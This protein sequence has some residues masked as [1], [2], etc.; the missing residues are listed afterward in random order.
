M[1]GMMCA[2]IGSSIYLTFATRIGLPCSTT[3][4]IMGGVIGTGVALVG[5]DGIK[6]WGGNIHS[7]VVQVFLAWVIAPV[8][9]AAFASIIFLITK[10]GVLRR[11]E[12]A[13][14]ALMTVPV[15][16]FVTCT[17]LASTSLPLFLRDT[18]R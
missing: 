12:P 3:H 14:R 7:G 16:F 10:H 9:A 11:S 8:I 1:L 4:S 18:N 15:Y 13:L 5:A 6:W 17:L 2:L